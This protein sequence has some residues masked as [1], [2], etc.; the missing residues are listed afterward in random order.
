MIVAE[1]PHL[2]VAAITHPGMK[3]KENEDRYAIAAYRLSEQNA[4]ASVLIVVADGVGGHRAGEIASQIAVESIVQAVAASDAQH[5]V[6]T[7]R[8]AMAGASQAIVES[9]QEDQSRQGMGATCVCAWVIGDRLYATWVGDSRLYLVRGDSI[10]Q[11]TTDHTWIQEAL[12]HGI[13]TPDQVAGH[14]NAHVIHR[15]LGSLNHNEPDFHLRAHPNEEGA[16]SHQGMRIQ[17]GDRLL[18]CTDGLT[19]LVTAPEIHRAVIAYP[20]EQAMQGLVNLANARG[21]HDNITI[22]LAEVPENIAT[23]EYNGVPAGVER[24]N[25]GP[26]QVGVGCILI[27][28]LVSLATLAILL[29]WWYFSRTSSVS[30]LQQTVQHFTPLALIAG[31]LVS[32]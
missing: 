21:G 9:A 18:L 27:A 15:H 24:F 25:L 2:H 6:E 31:L 30:A 17:A 29:L 11:V 26:L 14:P 13:L 7:L 1:H 3:G 22:A 19:D 23:G 10:W 8:Y 28:A 20:R 16:E 32:R 12:T 4:T 5:P